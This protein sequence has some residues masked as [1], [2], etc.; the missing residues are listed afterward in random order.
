MEFILQIGLEKIDSV[1]NRVIGD[2]E[3][4]DDIEANIRFGVE[5]KAHQV[6]SGHDPFDPT[7]FLALYPEYREAWKRGILLA[8]ACNR[9]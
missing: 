6:G 8:K 7:T 5:L 9:V 4:A 2:N 3:E 1:I